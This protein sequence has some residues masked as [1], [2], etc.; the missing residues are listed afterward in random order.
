M[1]AVAHHTLVVSVHTSQ[2]HASVQPTAHHS[3][4]HSVLLAPEVAEPEG[5]A[6][7][8]GLEEV[9][10]QGGIPRHQ[11]THLQG[12]WH[13]AEWLRS[14]CLFALIAS[15]LSPAQ[16]QPLQCKMAGRQPAKLLPLPLP[17]LCG[18]GLKQQLQRG[19]CQSL[20]LLAAAGGATGQELGKATPLGAWI[21]QLQPRGAVDQPLSRLL[22]VAARVL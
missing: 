12:T 14:A 19:Q 10:Q 2:P 22:A 16:L 17:H 13:R 8:V 7:G 11:R 5:S 18:G 1:R 6:L 21:L 3:S 4:K 15:L 9:A 20:M